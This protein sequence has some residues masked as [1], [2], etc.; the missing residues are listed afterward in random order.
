VYYVGLLAGQNDMALLQRSGVGRD[1]NR[2]RFD[3]AA[4]EAALARPVV[5]RLF[6]LIRL[7]NE[8]PA[9]N[10]TFKLHATGDEELHLQW[11]SKDSQISLTVN[12][13]TRDHRIVS[14]LPGAHDEVV[15]FDD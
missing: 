11:S 5:Q 7:R 3:A 14:R 15:R 12:L 6:Q 1:I 10:G 13:R 9:F 4:F 2:Q 8:H